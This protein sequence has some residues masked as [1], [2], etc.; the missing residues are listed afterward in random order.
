MEQ[1]ER[2]LRE[3]PSSVHW[4]RA[5]KSFANSVRPVKFIRVAVTNSTDAVLSGICFAHYDLFRSGLCRHHSMRIRRRLY[6]KRTF[7]ANCMKAG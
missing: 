5:P 2:K 4:V 1:R 7:F 6:S 3:N